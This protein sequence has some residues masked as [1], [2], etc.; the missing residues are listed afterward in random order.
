MGGRWRLSGFSRYFIDRNGVASVQGSVR[1]R[2]SGHK[3]VRMSRPIPAFLDRP[4]GRRAISS[5]QAR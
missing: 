1:R 4:A 2:L 3:V 5:L